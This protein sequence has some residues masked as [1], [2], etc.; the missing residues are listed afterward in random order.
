LRRKK[1]DELRPRCATCKRLGIRCLEYGNKPEYMDGGLQ[2]KKKAGEIKDAIKATKNRKEQL[3]CPDTEETT[4]FDA[5]KTPDSTIPAQDRHISYEKPRVITS[6]SRSPS[7]SY[8]CSQEEYTKYVGSGRVKD[9][10]IYN[11]DVEFGQSRIDNVEWLSPRLVGPNNLSLGVYPSSLETVDPSPPNLYSG[12]SSDAILD[13]SLS[14]SI[15]IPPSLN[16]N[17]EFE[18]ASLLMH[19]VDHVLYIQFPFYNDALSHHGRAWLLSL[20][21]TV[22]PICRSI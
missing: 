15:S 18:S 8:I 3:R 4:N 13:L 9:Q 16:K 5:C 6:T 1:C 11:T 19:Y 10:A 22:K 12:F 2:E 14:P 20:I 17:I 21:T 7:S